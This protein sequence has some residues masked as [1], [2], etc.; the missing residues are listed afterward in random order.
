MNG[1]IG[2]IDTLS[3]SELD[4]DQRRV[5]QTMQECSSFLLRIIDDI[6]DS[7]K[8]ETK[9]INSMPERTEL[10]SWFESSIA[11]LYPIASNKN[12]RLKVHFDPDLPQFVEMDQ[13]RIRQI[14]SNLGNNAIKFSSKERG[15]ELG[16]VLVCLNRTFDNSLILVVEDDGIGIAD[17]KLQEIFEPFSTAERH[18]SAW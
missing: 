7:S 11:A 5:L 18:T 9:G 4:R 10:L 2:L 13:G 8:L 6:L 12:V 3:A 1:V 17:D 14:L 15:K 16:N